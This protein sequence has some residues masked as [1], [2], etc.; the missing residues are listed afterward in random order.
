MSRT[1]ALALLSAGCVA[2]CDPVP[3]PVVCGVSVD[4]GPQPA[5]EPGLCAAVEAEPAGSDGAR[6]SFADEIRG[7]C[8]TARE[9]AGCFDPEFDWIWVRPADALERTALAHELKHRRLWLEGKDLDY[10]HDGEIWR[11]P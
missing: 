10:A 4:W 7:E 5:D 3:L 9:I 1:V 11:H 6:V 8:R 2:A